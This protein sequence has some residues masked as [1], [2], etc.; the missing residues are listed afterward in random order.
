MA[1]IIGRRY[2]T[3]KWFFSESKSYAGSAAFFISSSLACI[4]ITYWMSATGAMVLPALAT[5]DLVS[6]IVLINFVCTFV[7]LL[8]IGDDNYT[9][10]L[11]G[12][13]LT[14]LLLY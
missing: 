6:R 11:T 13:V 12:A 1:D 4:G 8:P 10:P 3:T 9:V 5:S 2:G 14:Q 7:E